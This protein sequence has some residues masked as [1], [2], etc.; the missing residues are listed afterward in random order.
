ME[1]MIE[2]LIV[3]IIIL[4]IITIILLSL[5]PLLIS[6]QTQ[7]YIQQI[8]QKDAEINALKQQYN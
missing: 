6:A 8:K 4:P 5:T 7:P 2:L 1:K 3:A